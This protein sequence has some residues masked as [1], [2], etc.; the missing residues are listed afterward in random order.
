ME[1]YPTLKLSEVLILC[2]SVEEPGKHYAK[3]EKPIMKEHI[4]YDSMY[5]QW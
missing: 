3:S 2:Y 1:H 5:M 4:W